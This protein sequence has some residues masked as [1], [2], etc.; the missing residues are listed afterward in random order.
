MDRTLP[1]DDAHDKLPEHEGASAFSTETTDHEAPTA[2][3]RHS[4]TEL[5]RSFAF[6]NPGLLY[7]AGGVDR[8]PI[9][10]YWIR[11]DLPMEDR[12]A[13]HEL[14][15]APFRGI[16]RPGETNELDWDRTIM[17]VKHEYAAGLFDYLRALSV[18]DWRRR[19]F[20]RTEPTT[21]SI[22][23]ERAHRSPGS[24]GLVVTLFQV[25]RDDVSRVF[26]RSESD[27]LYH[28]VRW[29]VAQ[30]VALFARSLFA[31]DETPFRAIEPRTHGPLPQPSLPPE[32]MLAT[33]EEADY[34]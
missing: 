24:P 2:P 20:W 15:Y 14:D 10:D 5:S 30:S 22:D 34:A 9:A 4:L 3:R 31:E 13:L 25:F 19:R 17:I 1:K 11:S 27:Q 16:M 33:P 23:E 7:T 21:A 26:I 28:A 8:D 6:F 12:P 32:S 18:I 29:P